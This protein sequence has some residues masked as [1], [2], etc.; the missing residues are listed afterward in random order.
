MSLPDE[1]LRKLL[2]E[3]NDRVVTSSKAING[4]RTLMSQKERERR[5]IELT[6]RELRDVNERERG[7]KVWKGVGKM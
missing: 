2:Q 3:L 1:A 4:T 5:L 6:R 7:E